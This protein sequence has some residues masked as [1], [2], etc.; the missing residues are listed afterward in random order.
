M[1][2]VNAVSKFLEILVAL[3]PPLVIPAPPAED[4]LLL[5]D[6]REEFLSG[7]LVNDGN[8]RRAGA[9]LDLSLLLP[10]SSDLSLDT[11]LSISLSFEADRLLI[12]LLLSIPSLVNSPPSSS[13][14]ARGGGEMLA[15]G[16]LCLLGS[17]DD[18]SLASV[19][20]PW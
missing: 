20:G 17:S 16:I 11:L 5:G 9:D 2:E 14:P 15:L 18:L 13:I 10:R 12:F 7:D 4:A 3:S 19:L 1:A 6:P 8:S